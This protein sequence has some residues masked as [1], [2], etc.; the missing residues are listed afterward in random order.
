[1]TKL[2]VFPACRV[3]QTAVRLLLLS[4]SRVT[5]N[6]PEP[7]INRPVPRESLGNML[8]LLAL[9]RPAAVLV[10]ENIVADMLDHLDQESQ[11]GH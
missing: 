7:W 11:N 4:A 1:M 10:L 6:R 9:R 5:L 2:F 8:Q 3:R